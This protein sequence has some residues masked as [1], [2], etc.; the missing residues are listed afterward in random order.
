MENLA[1]LSLSIIQHDSW[2]LFPGSVFPVLSYHHFSDSLE[3]VLAGI[4][5]SSHSQSCLWSWLSE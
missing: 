3:N 1:A 2:E 5:P 4:T